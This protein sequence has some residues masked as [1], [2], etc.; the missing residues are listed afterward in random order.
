ME[1]NIM[2]LI[3]AIKKDF[4]GDIKVIV[5][6]AVQ[7]AL[8]EKLIINVANPDEPKAKA[9]A[10]KVTKEVA[11]EAMKP[12]TKKEAV[13]EENIEEDVEEEAPSRREELEAMS[14]NDLKSLVKSLGGKAV[15]KREV[16]I[17]A[18]LE[19]EAQS[20]DEEVEEE[21]TLEL[22]DETVEDT[23]EDEEEADDSEEEDS[24][25]DEEDS[26][27]EEEDGDTEDDELIDEAEQ[28]FIDFLIDL[29]DDELLEIGAKLGYGKPKNWDKEGF[30]NILV[31]NLEQL[32]EALSALG[33]YDE[34]EEESEDVEED[35]EVVEDDNELKAQ[36][37]ALTL[38]E[39]A[40]LCVE[41]ELSKKGKK[42]A[43]IDRLLKA[44]ADGEIEIDL[45]GVASED[46]S[47]EESEDEWYTQEELEDLDDADLIEIAEVNELE[48][49]Y[50]KKK[51]K[52][53]LDRAT[54]IDAILSLSDEEEDE[55]EEVIEEDDSNESESSTSEFEVSEERYAREEE[56]EEEIRAKYKA[57]KLK[58][59]VIKKFLTKYNEG[60]PTY[61]V[62]TGAEA[63]EEYIEIKTSMVDDEGESYDLED[64]YVRDGK[65]FCCG[66]ELND[67]DKE[68][69][70]SVCGTIYEA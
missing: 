31:A 70:C 25:E 17:E 45:D 44:Q 57:K 23:Q 66:R 36:L 56:I 49:P 16:I 59:A 47:E 40:D 13:A 48:I 38:E 55:D 15:G 14:Y 33:Y 11:K 41:Y 51:N 18:I 22:E 53:T 1:N 24:E 4:M 68:P 9:V 12:M 2:E 8:T 21:E 6:E 35:E 30:V 29:E 32:E 62:P 28:E 63:L 43:L 60:N 3:G 7:E 37:E 67:L 34:D 39:L 69:Y 50:V 58:D 64:C 54:L 19:L 20:A 42:Q 65:Y 26:E 10:E 27:D 61:K 46:D 52:K 5:R